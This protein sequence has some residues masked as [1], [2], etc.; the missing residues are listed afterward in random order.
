VLYNAILID[1][2]NF[3][4]RIKRNNKEVVDLADTFVSSINSD[5]KPYLK[6]DGNLWLLFDPIP[7]S[8]LGI[9][10]YFNCNTLRQDILNTYKSNRKHD[11]IVA[12]T[13]KFLKQY[14]Y[15]RGEHILSCCSEHLEADD[16]V[17]PIIKRINQQQKP[18]PH[19]ALVTTDMDWAKYLSSNCIIINKTFDKPFTAEDYEAKHKFIPTPAS[20]TLYK[21][22]FGDKSDNIAG[23]ANTKPTK[24]LKNI[25]DDIEVWIASVAKNNEDL[26]TILKRM[27]SYIFAT[28]VSK[29][30][31]TLE[32]QIWLKLSSGNTKINI[33]S[34]LFNNINVIKSRCKDLDNHITAEP[35]NEQINMLLDESIG[36]G[37]KT[38][39][40]FKFG[41]SKR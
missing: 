41:N 36:H 2:F 32:E 12:A 37:K 14:Y 26:E 28:V 17:E 23:A 21:A 16:Y 40:K 38:N 8:D 7:K 25:Y 19:I 11:P 15:Y 35:E 5:I 3:I 30:D 9:N 22:F 29:T 34:S 4:Y 10:K 13:A 6:K 27:K 33:L 18:S 39:K 24:Q 1:V 31:P 20:V